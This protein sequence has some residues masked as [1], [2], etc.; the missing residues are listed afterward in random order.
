[1]VYISN[2]IMALCETRQGQLEGCGEYWMG[3]E[4]S[5]MSDSELRGGSPRPCRLRT[6]CLTPVNMFDYVLT[7]VR[8]MGYHKFSS[9]CNCS[10]KP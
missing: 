10:V 7:H 4:S 6:D 2:Q 3:S 9:L 5:L 8:F 1:V